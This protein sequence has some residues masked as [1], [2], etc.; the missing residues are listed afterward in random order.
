MADPQILTTL[1]RKQ[2]GIE[3]AM[4][5]YEKRIGEARRDLA[6]INAAILSRCVCYRCRKHPSPNFLFFNQLHRAPAA[7]REPSRLLER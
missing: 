7:K 3:N 6:A 5:A 4:P 2:A 1:W